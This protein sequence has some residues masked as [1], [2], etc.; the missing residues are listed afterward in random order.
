M[1]EIP[2]L[3]AL[4]GALGEEQSFRE[5]AGQELAR[6][7]LDNIPE[8]KWPSLPMRVAHDSQLQEVKRLVLQLAAKYEAT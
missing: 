8:D 5:A 7:K 1:N 3:D 2:D 4:R 6:A